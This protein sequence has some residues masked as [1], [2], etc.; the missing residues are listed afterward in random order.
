MEQVRYGHR[1]AIGLQAGAECN[2]WGFVRS[3][4]IDSLTVRNDGVGSG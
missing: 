2:K 3:F 1:N 4:R